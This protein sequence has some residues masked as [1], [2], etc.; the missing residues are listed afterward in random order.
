MH[1]DMNKKR[2]ERSRREPKDPYC[3][4]HIKCRCDDAEISWDK[5][6]VLRLFAR[7]V[8]PPDKNV[9]ID[10]IKGRLKKGSE[11][12]ARRAKISARGPRTLM[13]N[14][15]GNGVTVIFT[16][17]LRVPRVRSDEVKSLGVIHWMLNTLIIQ[18]LLNNRPWKDIQAERRRCFYDARMS[19]EARE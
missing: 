3:G 17:G 9:I 10:R 18:R 15:N 6:S 2:K 16:N 14:V 13:R 19:F 11:P 4:C 1:K 7:Q 8:L 5:M 12:F